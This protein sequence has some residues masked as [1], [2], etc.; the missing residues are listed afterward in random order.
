V[1]FSQDGSSLITASDDKTAKV[2]AAATAALLL[3]YQT[4]CSS[5]E[6]TEYAHKCSRPTNV[7]S[8]VALQRVMP[9]CQQF[10]AAAYY[11]DWRCSSCSS[12][13]Y[14]LQWHMGE[15]LSQLVIEIAGG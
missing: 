6:R 15:L 4:S 3:P 12:C 7:H 9:L 8:A 10:Q 2:S 1:N 5:S 11:A 14:L 13:M